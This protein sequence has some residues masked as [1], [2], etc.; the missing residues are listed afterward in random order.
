MACSMTFY[1]LIVDVQELL[2][3]FIWFRR[4]SYGEN[5]DGEPLLFHGLAVAGL[6]SLTREVIRHFAISSIASNALSCSSASVRCQITAI[7]FEVGTCRITIAGQAGD[8]LLG[9]FQRNTLCLWGRSLYRTSSVG[10]RG[11]R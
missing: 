1:I 7:S 5:R 2:L 8:I 11:L 3:L 4:G 9:R 6:F 10:S